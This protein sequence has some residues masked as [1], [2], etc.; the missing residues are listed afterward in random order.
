MRNCDSFYLLCEKLAQELLLVNPLT[1][2]F[3][4]LR[5]ENFGFSVVD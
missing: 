1:T 2:I 3:M 5:T 4:A